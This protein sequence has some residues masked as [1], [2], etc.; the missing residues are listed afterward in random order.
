MFTVELTRAHAGPVVAGHPWVFAQAVSRVR[1]TPEPGDE[2]QV[3]DADQ[4]ALGRGLWSPSSAIVVRLLTRDHDRAIDADLLRERIQNAI[5]AR[6]IFGLPSAETTGYRLI[7]SE[8]DYLPGLTVDRYGDTLV[9]QLGT[10]GM[11][12]RKGLLVELLA[13]AV[14]PRTI[15]EVTGKNTAEREGFSVEPAVLFG[16]KGSTLSFRERGLRFSL[17]PDSMQ[18]TGYY[19]D[20]REHRS[21]V[22]AL[23]KDRDVIDI[24]SYVG[25]F[26]L[27]AARGGAKRV[28]A[29]DSSQPALDVGAQIAQENGVSSISFERADARKDLE[30]ISRQG[31]RFDLVILDPPKLV[32]SAKHFERGRK[33][34]R[35]I[36][37][38]ALAL[39]REG[40]VFV[41]C[42]CSAGMTEVDFLRTI[43]LA[44]R[45][46]RR[47]LSIFRVGRQ[48]PD[49]PIPP[50]FSEGA[51]LKT[52]FAVVR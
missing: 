40:G 30:S 52:V 31:D 35:Q 45:D 51:Y 44:A 15:V 23:A 34:Y 47:E 24:C 49:H 33:A 25:G 37:R 20:Q 38:H 3:L 32:P 8:G 26:A 46:A 13:E 11:Q 39:V 1:G 2:V 9:A 50:G 18:K 48:S 36:N 27:A 19:F 12:R 42:S 6:A 28:R 16:D 17:P 4:R 29:L 43:S 22:E 21:V 5:V 10:I 41:T 7:N 14:G